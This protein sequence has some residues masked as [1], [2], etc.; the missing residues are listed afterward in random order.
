MIAWHVL[1]SF[2]EGSCR[3]LGLS[4]VQRKT[5]SITKSRPNKFLDVD[6]IDK[7][8]LIII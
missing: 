7:V 8:Y 1:T 2:L 3:E 5:E 6:N 4:V